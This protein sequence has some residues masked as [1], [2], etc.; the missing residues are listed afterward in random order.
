MKDVQKNEREILEDNLYIYSSATGTNKKH[1]VV[2][3]DD[4]TLCNRADVPVR[5][6]GQLKKNYVTHFKDFR[7]LSDKHVCRWCKL[8]LMD[9]SVKTEQTHEDDIE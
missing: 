9:S 5:K 1:Y 2:D 6:D 4:T 7:R 8:K 3:G